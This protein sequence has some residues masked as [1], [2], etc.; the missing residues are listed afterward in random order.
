M[1]KQQR[2]IGI[3]II[4]LALAIYFVI[5][6]LC[7]I[8]PSLGSSISSTEVQALSHIFASASVQ[9]FVCIVLG[10]LL[11]ACGIVF[12]IKVFGLDLGKVDDIIK[13]STL[14]LWIIVTVVALIY[15]LSDFKT[16]AVFHWFLSLAKNALIIGGI[17]TIKNGK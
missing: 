7:L 12:L 4:Q 5:T 17:L 16:R 15:Y 1:A 10:I 14:I 8:A 6:G 11:L 9:K 13:Y 2:T 3:L